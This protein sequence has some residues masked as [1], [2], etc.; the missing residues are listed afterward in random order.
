MILDLRTRTVARLRAAGCVFA[1]DEAELLL[2]A[3][4]G[5]ALDALVARRVAGEPLE[6]LLGWVEFA[7]QRVP[8]DPG[9]FTPRRRTELLVELAVAHGGAVVVD[10]C[11]GAG[12]VGAAVH[13]QLGGGEL[14]AADVEPAAVACARRAVE[15]LGGRVVA[16]DLYAALPADLRGRVDLLCVNAPYVP[17]AAVADMPPEARDHEPLVALDGGDDGLDL[18]RRVA[19]GAADWL[20]EDGLLLLETSRGQADR[21]AALV[22]EGGLTAEVVTDPDEDRGGTVVVGRSARR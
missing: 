14:V 6:H 17:S 7:G 20:A 9:V 1:E 11:C 4:G 19:A 22:R 10:L 2:E 15:P 21:T 8:V 12:A 5:A 16:G 3:A 13:R 18:H